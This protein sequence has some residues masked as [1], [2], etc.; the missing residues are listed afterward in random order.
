MASLGISE[1]VA[2][3]ICALTGEQK[4]VSDILNLFIDGF[5]DLETNALHH[6]L[7][8]WCSRLL[9]THLRKVHS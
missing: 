3:V 8:Y 2:R 7:A 4:K 6:F 5:L 1:L 9:F